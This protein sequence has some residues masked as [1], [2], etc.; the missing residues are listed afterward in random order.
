MGKTSHK[1][2]TPPGEFKS[3]TPRN[4]SINN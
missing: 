4:S 3:T 1:T 2:K